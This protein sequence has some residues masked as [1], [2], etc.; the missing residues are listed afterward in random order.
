MKSIKLFV[1]SALTAV[2][3]LSCTTSRSQRDLGSAVQSIR[4]YVDSF[5]GLG[6]EAVR[7]K[8]VAAKLSEEDWKEGGFGGRQLVA[9]FPGYEIRVLFLDD[10]AITT[11]FQL[12]SK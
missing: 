8:L 1:W 4:H 11:S 2:F 5:D 9:T 3:L 6:M 10:R 12:L 7:S